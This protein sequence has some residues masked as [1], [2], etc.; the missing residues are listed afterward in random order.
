MPTKNLR[1]LARK[2]VRVGALSV[3]F[4][5]C[6][7]GTTQTA[8]HRSDI[9]ETTLS[10]AEFHRQQKLQLAWKSDNQLELASGVLF[11][12]HNQ[13]LFFEGHDTIERLS[14][15]SSSYCGVADECDISQEAKRSPI[16]HAA[17]FRTAYEDALELCVWMAGLENCLEEH[18]ASTHCYLVHDVDERYPPLPIAHSVTTMDDPLYR[19]LEQTEKIY[20]RDR[21][22][23]SEGGD[24]A[25]FAWQVNVSD[26]KDA[27]SLTRK[28]E[29]D[30][31][32]I[33]ARRIIRL[34]EQ[35]TW[36]WGKSYSYGVGRHEP[37]APPIA[38]EGRAKCSNAADG[39]TWKTIGTASMCIV[40]LGNFVTSDADSIELDKIKLYLSHRACEQAG[41]AK[42]GKRVPTC[43][44]QKH[45][46]N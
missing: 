25:C 33:T 22:L 43:G 40:S 44:R 18:P 6:S 11:N 34:G 12:V 45:R 1:I 3:I 17:W 14:L 13:A 24:D 19:V 39:T 30:G 10:P 41:R 23:T 29:V 4:G 46:A 2:L 15:H 37:D 32:Q 26:T 7:Q 16:G 20:L 38:T 21:G 8:R 27:I 42:V 9:I 28:E 5:G 36:T 31:A 35:Y